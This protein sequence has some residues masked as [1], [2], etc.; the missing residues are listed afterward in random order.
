MVGRPQI[1]ALNLLTPLL[2]IV[3]RALPLPPLS[4][5][6]VLRPSPARASVDHRD[7]AGRPV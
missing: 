6:A 1:R 7:A 3:D 2:R 4:L 5:I